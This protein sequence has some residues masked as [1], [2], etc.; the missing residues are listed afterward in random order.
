VHVVPGDRLPDERCEEDP[1]EEQGQRVLAHEPA[2]GGL[3]WRQLWLRPMTEKK[4]RPTTITV[5]QITNITRIAATLVGR[6]RA[7]FPRSCGG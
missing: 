5:S 1:Q 2:H 6:P 3:L 7:A 4:I